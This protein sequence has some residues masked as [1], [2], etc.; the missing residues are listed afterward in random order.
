MAA[1]SAKTLLSVLDLVTGASSTEANNFKRT[2]QQVVEDGGSHSLFA[3]LRRA[4]SNRL[5]SISEDTVGGDSE[6]D[7]DFVESLLHLTPMKDIKVGLRSHRI[8][9]T[10]L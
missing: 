3:G 5:S 7:K 2:I 6:E 1:E 8:T 9:L 10:L 4:E